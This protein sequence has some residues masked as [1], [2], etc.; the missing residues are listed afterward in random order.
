MA[1]LA[2]KFIGAGNNSDCCGNN[3]VG[4]TKRTANAHEICATEENPH[5]NTRSDITTRNRG[6]ADDHFRNGLSNSNRAIGLVGQHQGH[7]SRGLRQTAL[8]KLLARW[9]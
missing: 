1:A 6:S 3:A 4:I 2:E 7:I 8:T 9:Q 5:T